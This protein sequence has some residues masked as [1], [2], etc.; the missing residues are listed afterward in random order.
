MIWQGISLN[1][2]TPMQFINHRPWFSYR[3]LAP[4]QFMPMLGVHNANPADAFSR[5]RSLRLG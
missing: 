5:Y 1:R 2:G 3:G 4:H